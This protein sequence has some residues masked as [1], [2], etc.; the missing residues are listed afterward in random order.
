MDISVVEGLEAEMD[1]GAELRRWNPLARDPASRRASSY[2]AFVGNAV[3][4]PLSPTRPADPDLT[5]AHCELRA[6][7][8][9]DGF[10]CVGAKS[11]FNRRTYRFGLYPDLVTPTAVHGLCHDLYEFSH[12]FRE[13]GDQFTTFVAM[14]RGPTI[15]SE[16]HFEALLWQHLQ[17]MHDLDGTCFSWDARVS[18]D[19][20]HPEFSFSIGGRGFFVVGLN[21]RASRLARALSQ[22]TLVFNLHEQFDE[23]RARGKFETMKRIIRARDM[24]YQG[25]INPVL[26]DF[27]QSS[28]ARQYSGRAVPDDWIC[29]FQQRSTEEQ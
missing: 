12:E 21:P 11:A 2:A 29:P 10:P 18:A 16:L 27:G 3:V 4:H 15:E 26:K 17:C 22:P 14:F 1:A 6:H 20:A 25:S 19:P 24:A 7:V 8:M 5:Q 13:I 9:G 23:L 28:E